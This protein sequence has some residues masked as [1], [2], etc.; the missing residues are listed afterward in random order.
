MR[1]EEAMKLMREGKW[2]K[3]K[4]D[5]AVYYIRDN[6][7]MIAHSFARKSV[8][9]LDYNKLNSE[10]WVV[11]EGVNFEVGDIIGSDKG[12]LLCITHIEFDERDLISA[13]YAVRKNGKFL[14]IS[15]SNLE[16]WKLVKRCGSWRK[17]VN[18]ELFKEEESND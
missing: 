3:V 10:N 5:P 9:D 14:Y 7:L 1:F 8:S 11:Y 12:A 15:W 4:G 13:V 18:D 17:A 6:E 16:G 2:C